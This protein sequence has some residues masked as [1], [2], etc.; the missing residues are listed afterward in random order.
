MSLDQLISVL[1]TV[2]DLP[3]GWKV[4]TAPAAA[5]EDDDNST[6]TPPECGVLFDGLRDGGGTR[7]SAATATYSAGTLGPVLD[8]EIRYYPSGFDASAL[9]AFAEALGQCPT[10]TI[11]DP[12]EGSI[13]FAASALSFPNLGDSTLAVRLAA[14]AD[15]LELVSDTVAVGLDRYQILFVSGGLTTMDPAALESIA[16]GTVDRANGL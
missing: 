14:E 2:E 1:P 3:T 7:D 15:G 8:V 12:A 16:R 6:V 5:P 11:A 10:F 4:D 13:T 9:D